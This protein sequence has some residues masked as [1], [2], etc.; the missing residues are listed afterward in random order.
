MPSP[1]RGRPPPEGRIGW[2]GSSC[3]EPCD[4]TTLWARG[5]GVNWQRLRLDDSL[6]AGVFDFLFEN[7][8][9]VAAGRRVVVPLQDGRV[10]A[11][12]W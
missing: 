1:D 8:P 7:V 3:R 2:G 10:L 6:R 12:R 4:H 11:G 5:D 9:T